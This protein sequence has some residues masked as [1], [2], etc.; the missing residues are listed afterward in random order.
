MATLTGATVVFDLDGTLVDTAPDIRAAAN[1]VLMDRGLRSLNLAEVRGLIGHGARGFFIQAFNREEFLVD[2]RELTLATEQFRDLYLADIAR[3]SRPFPGAVDALDSL[4]ASGA[5]LTLCTNK[6][7][8]QTRALL[9]ALN[10]SSRFA[11]IA[12]PE[13][14]GAAKPDPAH[15]LAGIASAGGHPGRSVMVGDSRAD[16]DAARAAGVPL[17]LVDFGYCDEAVAALE[18]DLTISHFKEL[19]GAVVSLIGADAAA[20][21]PSPALDA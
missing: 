2:E 21:A 5:A 15:L 11:A 3:E 18:P 10:L 14:S 1:Q 8:Q 17:V 4:M 6:A 13:T 12:T 9:Q 7:E 16:A 19:P 20:I